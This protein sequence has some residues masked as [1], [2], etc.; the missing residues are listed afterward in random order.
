[1]FETYII[2]T[3]INISYSKSSGSC[4]FRRVWI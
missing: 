2:K 4:V 1:M 3:N